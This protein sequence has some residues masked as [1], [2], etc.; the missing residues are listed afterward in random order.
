MKKSI[1][2]PM[3]SNLNH[4][5]RY[6]NFQIFGN[7]VILITQSLKKKSKDVSILLLYDLFM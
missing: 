3:E 6:E 4:K 2:Y 7:N 1:F 5:K